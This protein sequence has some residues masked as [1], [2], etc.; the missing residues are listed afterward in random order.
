[1]N[2]KSDF[3]YHIPLLCESAVLVVFKASLCPMCLHS[4]CPRLSIRPFS[5]ATRLCSGSREVVSFSD[6]R[7]CYSRCKCDCKEMFHSSVPPHLVSIHLTRRLFNHCFALS[8]KS[9]PSAGVV[10][11]QVNPGGGTIRGTDHNDATMRF[12]GAENTVRLAGRLHSQG[13]AQSV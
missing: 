1:M 5:V 4:I 6:V 8:L 13:E 11:L 2:R 3:P 10:A 7:R 12:N 9:S